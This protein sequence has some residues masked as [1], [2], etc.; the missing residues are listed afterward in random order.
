MLR[1]FCVACAKFHAGDRLGEL[2]AVAATAPYF[3]IYH[4]AVLLH[5]RRCG[6]S[7]GLLPLVRHRR[8]MTSGLTCCAPAG[9]PAWRRRELHMAFVL[10]GLLLTSGECTARGCEG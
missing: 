5:A 8:L 4:A 9:L 10:A 7:A 3:A 6:A 1:T 2:L